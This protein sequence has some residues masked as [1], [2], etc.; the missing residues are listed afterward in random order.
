MRAKTFIVTSSAAG[1]TYS[2]AYPIDT[3]D[4]PTCI[5]VGVDIVYGTTSALYDVQHTFS[6]PWAI[7]LNANPIGN[8]VTTGIWHNNATLTS[9]SVNGDTNYA[10]PPRAIRF[11]LRAA[12]SAQIQGV[13]QQAGPDA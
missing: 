5:G 6:D 9:A 3:W 1:T 10:F 7:N 2:P 13:I 8:T 12:V 4:N 11:A